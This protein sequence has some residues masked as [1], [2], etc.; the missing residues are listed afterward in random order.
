[1]VTVGKDLGYPLAVVD[2][3]LERLGY[4]IDYEDTLE[5]L[6]FFEFEQ[7]FQKYTE[8]FMP[9]EVDAFILLRL[10]ASHLP[11]LN[12]KEK[13]QLIFAKLDE[14][15]SGELEVQEIVLLGKMLQPMAAEEEIKRAVAY[16]D[17]DNS[18][19]VDHEEFVTAMTAILNASE[20]ENVDA[21]ITKI[22]EIG[23]DAM[24]LATQYMSKPFKCA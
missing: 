20:T 14:D 10:G 19:S 22:M 6:E 7:I 21:A 2:E 23:V 24:D 15:H 1:M 12:N 5:P 4:H 3:M 13:A 8:D 11:F 17:A 16:L 9:E 18:Q